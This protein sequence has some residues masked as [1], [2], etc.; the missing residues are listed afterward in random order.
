MKNTKVLALAL[1]L[2]LVM[3]CSHKTVAITPQATAAQ[4]DTFALQFNWIK[5]KGKKYDM[6]LTVKNGLSKNVLFYLTD[7]NCFRGSVQGTLKHTFFNTGHRTFKYHPGGT[8]KFNM[9]CNLGQEST[10]A[11]KITIGHLYENPNGDG[12]TQGNQ[13]AENISVVQ[14]SGDDVKAAPSEAPATN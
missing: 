2:S 11:Y 1:F 9:V 6:Q 4:T 13:I 5:D 8:E 7:L 10:G 3:S 12:K 14:G